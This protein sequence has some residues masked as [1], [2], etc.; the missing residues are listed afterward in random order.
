M[1]WVY[2]HLVWAT[3]D[4]QPLL[5]PE[6]RALVYRQITVKGEENRCPVQAIGGIEDHV[7]V[8]VRFATTVTIA[9]LV[10]DMKGSSS[11]LVNHEAQASG[12]EPFFKWQGTYGVF[13][14]GP[15]G[16]PRVVRYVERQEEHHRAGS[17][18]PRL[19]QTFRPGPED[20]E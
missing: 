18:E 1:N 12:R 14:V 2:L 17:T 16:L 5:T 11:H 4:R 3:Y 10:K 13:P 19:E 15:D 20:A 6:I 9:K 8:V 7:H